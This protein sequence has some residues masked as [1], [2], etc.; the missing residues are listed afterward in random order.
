M[1]Y[2]LLDCSSLFDCNSIVDMDR[3]QLYFH[4]LVVRE[5]LDR[6]N[7]IVLDRSIDMNANRHNSLYRKD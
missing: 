2:Y 4:L 6:L 7:V 1:A 3:Q 5:N